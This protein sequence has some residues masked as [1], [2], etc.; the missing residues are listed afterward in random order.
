M[1]GAVVLLFILMLLA[2]IG[3][4]SPILSLLFLAF[5]FVVRF[6]SLIIGGLVSLAHGG[7]RQ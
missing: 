1:D 2:V 3:L 5:S 6:V 7:D 4:L